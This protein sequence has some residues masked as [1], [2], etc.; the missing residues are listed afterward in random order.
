MR[1]VDVFQKEDY[2]PI[3]RGT[4]FPQFYE[5]ND[6]YIPGNVMNYHYRFWLSATHEQQFHNVMEESYMMGSEL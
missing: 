2:Q 3:E 5:N 6:K 1:L 4:A